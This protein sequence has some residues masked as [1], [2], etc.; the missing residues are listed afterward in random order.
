MIY[1]YINIL[2]MYI[3]MIYIRFL[4]MY[5][6]IYS[7]FIIRN[8]PLSSLTVKRSVALSRTER[9]CCCSEIIC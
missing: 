3:Y 1:I 6:Y 5:M 9:L 4:Y 8:S 2:Y 7:P